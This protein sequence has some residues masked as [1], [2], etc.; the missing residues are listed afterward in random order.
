MSAQ[1][2]IIRECD[3]PTGIE[4]WIETPLSLLSDRTG[5]FACTVLLTTPDEIRRLNAEFRSCDK[6]TDV[7][8]F[9]SHNPD[10]A[11]EEDCFAGDIAICVSRAV[12]QAGELGHSLCR[13]LAFLALH[14]ALH[15]HGWD[16]GS[17]EEA[18][19]MYAVQ[20]EIVGAAVRLL[21]DD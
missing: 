3:A 5:D 20:R 14:G 16:H 8:S 1:V 13:E 17:E 6:V 7:L 21:H 15:L 10:E 12:Q 18:E 4:A 11:P 9:P 19:Q 2:T